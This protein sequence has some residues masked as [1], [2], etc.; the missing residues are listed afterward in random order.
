MKVKEL[1]KRLQEYPDNLYLNV[2]EVENFFAEIEVEDL[3][4]YFKDVGNLNISVRAYNAL[5]NDG[6]LT[7]GH[8]VATSEYEIIKIANL[9]KKSLVEIKKALNEIN[10][11]LGVRLP[12]NLM[13]SLGIERTFDCKTWDGKNS[14]YIRKINN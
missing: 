14:W 1:I 13:Y 10:L 5:R 2:S 9:G 8:L 4:I 11:S 3:R 12:N 7:I 6:I